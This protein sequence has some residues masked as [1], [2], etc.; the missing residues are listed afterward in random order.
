MRLYRTALA[1]VAAASVLAAQNLRPKDVREIA[2]GGS[3]AIPKLQ[4][5]LKNPD[6]DV[7]LEAVRQITEIGTERSL[8][9]LILATQDNDPEMQI[10]ATDGLVNFY[11][12]GYVKTGFGSTLSRVGTSIKGKF[13]DTNDQVI[14]PYITVRPQVIAAL[15]KL[16]RG[17]ADMNARENAARAI[18][19]LRGRAGVPD[20]LAAIRSKDTD[21][22]YESLIALQKIRDDSAA[23]QL[24]FLVRDLNP[25]VQTTAMETL[26]ILRDQQALPEIVDAL[27]RTRDDRVRRSALTAI[28]MLPA[29]SSRPLY[30]KY[31]GDKDDKMRAAAAEG[32]ARLKDPA[33]LPML[34]KAWMDEGKTPVRLALAFA[35]VSSGN[36]QMSEFSPLQYLTN[37]LNLAAWHGVAFAY[38]VEAARDS[39]VRAALF[40]ALNNGTKDE[41]ISL[42][43]VLARSGGAES[44]PYLQK[45]SNDT[46]GDVAREGARAL[47]NLKARI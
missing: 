4:E 47:R 15:G 6:I 41:K 27:N 26:G 13:T 28:A 20:L 3:N 24:D 44:V 8:D 2:K 40:P 7:R 14:D 10:R 9:P 17:G 21:V 42:A 35:L 36:I 29:E 16:A 11:L 46:D 1:A 33:D 19:I 39:N 30:A 12:P 43:Q 31:L 32:Y 18:G 34:Q 37:S 25:K 22:I 38:L 5:L 23:G 45:L